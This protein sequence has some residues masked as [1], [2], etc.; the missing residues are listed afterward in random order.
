MENCCG[1]AVISCIL[2]IFDVPCG[3]IESTGINPGIGT[4]QDT[5]GI[6]QEDVPA[7]SQFPEDAGHFLTRHQI[8]IVVGIKDNFF[9]LTNGELVPLQQI[10][11]IS[12]GNPQR[13]IRL[14]HDHIGPCST[15]CQF[16][17]GVSCRHKGERPRQQG[18]SHFGLQ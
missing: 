3:G 6:D 17:H 13:I 8:Q 7:A 12:T 16:R 5:I 1:H 4:E 2:D 14:L 9:R 15:S 18:Q 10:V 11:G